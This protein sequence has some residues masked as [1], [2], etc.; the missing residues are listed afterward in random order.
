MSTNIESLELEIIS[1]SQNA[2]NGLDALTNTLTKIEKATNKYT[3]ANKKLSASYTDVFAKIASGIHVFEKVGSKLLSFVK[4]ASDYNE[5][6][7]LFNQSMGEYAEE[8]GKYANE[9]S[10]AMGIDVSDWARNQGIFM[11]LAKGF[12][13]AGDRASL[14]S[15]QLTQL[16][17]DISSFFNITVDEAMQKLKSGF[18][19][20]L[21]PLRAIGYDLSQAKLEAVALSLGIDKT[22]SSM[23]QAEKAQLRYYAI[24]TQVTHVHGDMARTLEEPANQLRIFTTQLNMAARS[25]GSIF[26][27]ILNKVLPPLIAL[28]KVVRAIADIIAG[29]MGYT[30][31]EMTWDSSSSG[32]G[33]LADE[34]GNLTDELEN[35][36]EEAKKL[37]YYMMGFDELNVIN[38]DNDD[39]SLDDVLGDTGSG[40]FDFEL[41]TYDFLGDGINSIVNELVEK[42]KEWL[43]ITDEIDTWAELM[44]TRLGKILLTVGAI[45]VGLAAWKIAKGVLTAIELIKSLNPSGFSFALS[46]L[47]G[48]KMLADLEKLMGFVEDISKNGA[49]F[50]NV[51][52]LIAEF[53][54]VL[55]DAFLL[56]GGVKIAGVLAVVQ[57][58]GEIAS[59]ISDIAVNGAD[60]DNVMILIHGLSNIGFGIGLVTGNLKL[61]GVSIALQGLT[62]V[63]TELASNW[64]AIKNGDWSGVDKVS[65]VIG[66]IEIL[67]GVVT[68]LGVFDTLTKGKKIAEMT[69]PITE[70]GT[71]VE[72]VSTTTDTL[73]T[74]LTTLAKNLGLGVAII[75]EVAAA[76]VLIVGAIWLLGVELEQVGIA[77][78]PVI[79]NGTTVAIAVGLGTAILATVGTATALLGTL[80]GKVAGQIAIGIAILAELGVAAVLFVAEIWV[81]G[82]GLDEVG[83]AWDPVLKNGENIA[84]AIG[85]GTALLIGIGVVTAALGVATVASAGALP[86]AIASGTLLLIE[87]AEA[88]VAFVESLVKVADELSDELS[89]ALDK[90]NE[91]LPDLTTNLKSFT[92]FMKTFA[93]E[94]VDYTKSSA[95]SGFNATVDNVVKFFT[96][97]PIKKLAN[98]VN[99]QYE[100][101]TDL[102]KKLKLANPELETAIKWLGDYNL[103]LDEIHS[104]T[105]DTNTS[106]LGDNIFTNMK[107][108]GKKF[109][110]G[111]V[112][113]IESKSKSLKS[114]VEKVCE[115]AFSE[116]LAKRTGED[117]GETLGKA[118][119]N[120]IKSIDFPSIEGNVTIS[121]DGGA[122]IDFDA[123]ANG[124]F[125]EQGQLFIAREA[126]AEMV[127][128]IGGRTA[129]A[130]N[131]QI[132]EGIYQGVLAAMR[133]ADNGNGNDDTPSFNI[134]LDGKKIAASV[135]RRQSERGA[136]IYRG[137]VLLGV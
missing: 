42:M 125:P 21:E 82:K 65:L 83:K 105:K 69:K 7:N 72:T 5:N 68:A 130:N 107:D 113:G 41:P 127:G 108:A 31:P 30:L 36:Q 20:E 96:A 86:L 106:S 81:I 126:G 132:V 18:A 75:A 77:W 98:D 101:A 16:G 110:E 13:V 89:P 109:V 118:I 131:D 133:D 48:T 91:V 38:P 2:A 46:F 120:G 136:T 119:A 61:A 15:Q 84:T 124:G 11:T 102:N 97:D 25:I 134:Y 87:L 23:T 49:T 63:I 58:I 45:G 103:L 52:G 93:E 70:V 10:E 53:A 54:G 4:S 111:F 94:V 104:L 85:L 73:T 71:A 14:M 95:I 28:L 129:V 39:S 99:K 51:S 55:S 19:G 44:D 62:T 79:D 29:L 6:I 3:N 88:F 115:E 57:G 66:A 37:K 74:K 92:S 40:G 67:G 26:I 100:H 43:G 80:G 9:V 90:L 24:M 32:M 12:G 76:A 27:P 35:A 117:F 116:K 137:G 8:A 112:E 123:Y 122:S 22:V 60:F 50:S 78:Q 34:T 17:Y 114:S 47:G 33:D 121:G 1:N 56:L 59:A 135:E 64:E 128:S